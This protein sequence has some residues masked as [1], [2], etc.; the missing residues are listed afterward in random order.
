VHRALLAAGADVDDPLPAARLSRHAALALGWER[1]RLLC[2][3]QW[4]LGFASVLAQVEQELA[5]G[6]RMGHPPDIAVLF[7]KPAC[8]ARLLG[9]APVA[10]SLGPVTSYA[11][12]RDRMVVRAADKVF[13]KLSHGSSASGVLALRTSPR[14]PRAFT[15]VERVAGVGGDRLYNTQRIQLYAREVEIAAIVDALAREGVHVERWLPKAT[16][17]NRPLDLRVVT[18]AGRPRHI[19][20][21]VGRTVITNLHAGARR[22]DLEALDAKLGGAALADAR[23]AAAAAAAT[24]PKS[25]MTG[26]D[27]LLEPAGRAVVLEVNAF[28]DLLRGAIDD[29]ENPYEAQLAAIF[30]PPAGGAAE[31]PCPT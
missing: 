18:V 24:F 11:E 17:D 26:V 27:V 2:P 23:R 31:A 30:G 5:G 22:G 21:R 29:G 3:R 25:L 20:V 7:D 14:G 13:V 1:G 15:T 12:L 16:L 8:H 19:V 10:E 9:A 28:G 6:P 4:Y